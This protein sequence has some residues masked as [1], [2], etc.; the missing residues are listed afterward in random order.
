[1]ALGVELGE[2]VR[3]GAALHPQ[4]QW[5]RSSRALEPDGFHLED[6]QPQLFLD[7]PLDGDAAV[8]GHVEVCL[9]APPVGHGERFVGREPAKGDEGNGDTEDDAVDGVGRVVDRQVQ[10]GK[11][12]HRDGPSDPQLRPLT[13]PPGH[14]QRVRDAHEDQGEDRHRRRRHREP[15]PATDDRDTVR[16]GSCHV[17]DD[18]AADRSQDREA[19]EEREQVTPSPEADERDDNGPCDGG[20]PPARPAGV[21]RPH[22]VGEPSGPEVRELLEQP[23]LETGGRVRLADDRQQGE[24][25][26]GDRRQQDPQLAAH[27]DLARQRRRR[28]RRAPLATAPARHGERRVDRGRTSASR[29]HRAHAR[30]RISVST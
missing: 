16:P 6:G 14:D 17:V 4:A 29:H 11:R 25:G 30:T 7:G 21:D 28:A 20:R 23:C 27:S 26:G 8:A 10:P 12:E 13:R 19:P 22:D 5:R 1:M 2:Q 9:L 15:T 24:T 3:R 18:G